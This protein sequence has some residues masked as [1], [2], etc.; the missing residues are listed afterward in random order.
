[1]MGI[2]SQKLILIKEN[3]SNDIE[4]QKSHQNS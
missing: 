1:M 4:N 3:N 2:F